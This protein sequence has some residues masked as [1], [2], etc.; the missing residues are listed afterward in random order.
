MLFI[1]VRWNWM[2]KCT[3]ITLNFLE[4]KRGGLKR[5]GLETRKKMTLKTATRSLYRTLLIDFRWVIR[6]TL[7]N[8][9]F[10]WCWYGDRFYYNYLLESGL[11]SIEQFVI[12]TFGLTITS[13]RDCVYI[14]SSFLLFVLEIFVLK[15]PPQIFTFLTSHFN[16]LFLLSR[17]WCFVFF[18][19]Y[20]RLTICV[21]HQSWNT[22]HGRWKGTTLPFKCPGN[23]EAWKNRKVAI[24]NCRRLLTVITFLCYSQWLHNVNK[25][26]IIRIWVLYLNLKKLWWP[27]CHFYFSLE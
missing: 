10:Y 14:L 11:H 7:H 25:F 16:Q 1:L 3:N 15:F 20:T 8:Y 17:A 9:F 5:V 4:W 23:I 19:M 12:M 6:T 22:V 2:T 24:G 21:F 26:L 27:N 13:C 18:F